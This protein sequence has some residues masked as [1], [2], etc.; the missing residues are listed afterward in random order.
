M[1]ANCKKGKIA[2][3]SNKNIQVYNGSVMKKNQAR[4][5]T[6]NSCYEA[7]RKLYGIISVR[8]IGMTCKSHIAGTPVLSLKKCQSLLQQTTF[9][10]K[11]FFIVFSEKIRLNVSSESSAEQRIHMKNQ[12]LFSA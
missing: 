10:N 3:I 12:V 11:Y 6:V 7:V 5:I 4:Q 2:N 1:T 9:I 8:M